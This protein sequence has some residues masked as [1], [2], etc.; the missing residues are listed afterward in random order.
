MQGPPRH[1]LMGTCFTWLCGQ[2]QS[3]SHLLLSTFPAQSHSEVKAGVDREPE[4]LAQR[5]EVGWPLPPACKAWP[6]AA[7]SEEPSKSWRGGC[8]VVWIRG[9]VG[10]CRLALPCLLSTL[11]SLVFTSSL[12]FYL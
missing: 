9:R 11:F 10:D 3:F 1:Q 2:R 8:V 4:D 6:R 12:E 7:G 5:G